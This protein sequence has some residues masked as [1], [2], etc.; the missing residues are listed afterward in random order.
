MA[1]FFTLTLSKKKG[2]KVKVHLCAE[3]YIPGRGEEVQ[4]IGMFEHQYEAEI[5][6]KSKGN[7]KLRRYW[8]KGRC[9]VRG[10]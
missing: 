5:A 9:R 8:G 3:D 10:R 2:Q 4:V 6:R 7:V 1:K